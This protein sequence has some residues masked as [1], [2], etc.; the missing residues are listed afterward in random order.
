MKTLLKPLFAL[1]LAAVLFTGCSKDTNPLAP[2]DNGSNV[3]EPD[4]VPVKIPR[5]MRIED[6][7]VKHFP[8][9][10]LNGDTWDWDPI[11]AKQ[12]KPDIH[13]I[14]QRNS[15]Y[16]PV[17]W[18]DERK[19]ADYTSTYVFTRPASSYD[20]ELPYAVP[21]TQTWHVNLIDKDFGG[22]DK[23]GSVTVK[24]SSVYKNDNATNFSKTITSGD[25]KI[26]V[27]GAWIY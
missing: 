15:N 27:R 8:K 9:N 14:L 1:I 12:R 18:S 26:K 25:L 7:S 5:F 11:S 23:M 20:G 19:N 4:P 21:Y 2:S 3:T 6:I 10:K 24:P 16:L 22:T 13:V 17:F